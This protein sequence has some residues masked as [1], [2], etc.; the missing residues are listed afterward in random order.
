MPTILDI[1]LPLKF[2]Q[3]QYTSYFHFHH[4]V[5]RRMDGKASTGTKLRAGWYRVWILEEA[6]DLPLF[7][8]NQTSSGTHPASYSMATGGVIPGGK[9]AGTWD[10]ACNSIQYEG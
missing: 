8:N 1:A 10:W 6:Q 5:M 9:A 3:T 2:P 7:Q 4:N